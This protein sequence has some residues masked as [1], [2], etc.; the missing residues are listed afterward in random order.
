MIK[1]VYETISNSPIWITS[2]WIV[3]WD[4]HGGFYDHVAP[5]A[6]GA[7]ETLPNSLL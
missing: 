5:P 4:E 3:T 1:A 7:P 2:M 6:A